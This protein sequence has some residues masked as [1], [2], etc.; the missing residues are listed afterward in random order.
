MIYKRGNIYWYKFMW[1]GKLYRQSTRQGNPRV[2]RQMEAAHRTALAKGEVGLRDRRPVPTLAAFIDGRVLP[3]AEATFG[4]GC[5][6]NF[7]WYRDQCRVLRA[8]RPLAACTLDMITSES[9]AE[10]AAH[11]LREGKQV[12]TVNS[13][14][15]VLRRIL[16]LAVE[17]GVIDHAPKIKLL[18]GERR[19]ERVVTPEEEA[20]Y[21][22]AASEP[23][24]SIATVLVDTGMRPEECFRLRWEHVLWGSGRYGALLVTGGK[25]ASARRLL[26][27][28]PRVRA[29]LQARWNAAG[30]PVE[31]WVWPAR[32]R[33]GHVVPNSIYGQ[34]LAA[35]KASQVRPFVLYSLRHTFLTRLGASGCDAWT[36]ARIAGHSSVAVS[37]R[38]VHPSQGQIIEAMVRL[39]G[40]NSGHIGEGQFPRLPAELPASALQQVI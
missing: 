1:K 20:K 22:A 18:G 2:A 26:P 21:L 38:Y 15:R 9:A 13:A 19:R 23:L 16:N 5:P 3:W 7:K 36:L 34:H 31:G 14:L 37:A 25:T 10:F 29:V 35:L 28:T 12:A 39:S 4:T 33:C 6:K 32:T 11:R 17:W 27:M 30:R 8:Y 40:H 24:A